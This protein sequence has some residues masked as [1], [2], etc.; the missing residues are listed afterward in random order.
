MKKVAEILVESGYLN[1]NSF[2]A[3]LSNENWLRFIQG[4]NYEFDSK[5]D[6]SDAPVIDPFADTLEGRRQ[7]DAIEDWLY[8]NREILMIGSW[9]KFAEPLQTGQSQH[10]WRLDRIKWC[11]GKL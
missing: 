4:E 7:L 9:H 5:C 1:D 8:R 11:L 10:Q 6:P 2:I 3:G